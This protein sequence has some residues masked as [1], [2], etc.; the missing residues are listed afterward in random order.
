MVDGTCCEAAR[1]WGGMSRSGNPS[2][3]PTFRA[4]GASWGGSRG[5]SQELKAGGWGCKLRNEPNF[6]A[7]KPMKVHKCPKKRTQNE[8]NL[9][10]PARP[11]WPSRA[12]FNGKGLLVA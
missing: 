11:V 10:R 2:R 8:P 6:S 9:K 3:H 5:G 1:V 4:V 12:D 7:K